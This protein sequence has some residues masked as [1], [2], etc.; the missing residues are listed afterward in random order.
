MSFKKPIQL[1]DKT[2]LFL[3][4]ISSIL[5]GIWA[6][7][8]TIALRNVLLWA[9]SLVALVYWWSWFKSNKAR[10]S[11]PPLLGLYWLPLILI[12]MM[13]IWVVAHYFF[14]S[15][16][17]QQQFSELKGTWLRSFLAV[18]IGSATGIALNRNI[19]FMPWLWLGL[20]LS[21]IVLIYQYIPKALAKQSLFAVDWFGNYIYWAKFNGVLAGT[22]L[23]AG[24]L[25]LLIDSIWL[26]QNKNIKTNKTNRNSR[27]KADEKIISRPG[28]HEMETGFLNRIAMLVYIFVGIC[29]A[30]YAFVFIFDAKAGVGMAFILI[31]FWLGIGLLF[32]IK[33]AASVQD[34]KRRMAFLMKS[35]IIFSLVAISLFWFTAKH[36][37]NNPG[38]ESLLEDIAISA[39]VDEHLN[40]QNPSQ[41]GFPKRHDGTPVAGNTYERVSWGVVGYKLIWAEPLGSGL[42]RS[43]PNQVRKLAPEFNGA[44][45]THSAWIDLGLSFGIFG[46]IVM[47]L[48][49]VTAM[50]LAIF[51]ASIRYRAT[52]ISLALGVL[53]L[54]G[55]GEYGFQ[56]GIEILFYLGGLISCL[57]VMS[58]PSEKNSDC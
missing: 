28:I 15:Q 50:G 31:A 37:K 7:M 41:F 55:V 43:F 29:I 58:L 23:I 25:G 52:I 6:T 36:I 3:V 10:H 42:L 44:S 48:A 19:R 27:T 54:Y 35:L 22:I 21:F 16:N 56:H 46:F 53:I 12:G 11:L 49:L 33:N 38:W 1:P 18:I 14:F 8:N 47:P 4:I 20:L 13:F 57:T 51:T 45:Y 30:I 39:K 9:G 17:P 40:W 5:L 26:N 32:I 2:G 34:K 24:L